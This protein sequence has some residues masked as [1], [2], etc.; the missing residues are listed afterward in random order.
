MKTLSLVFALLAAI[1]LAPLTSYAD[2][3]RG[4]TRPPIR[5]LATT[6]F[7]VSF[8]AYSPKAYIKD[9]RRSGDLVLVDVSFKVTRGYVKNVQIVVD[10]KKVADIP[11]PGNN[12]SGSLTA[13]LSA[14]TM[15]KGTHSVVA[16]A[17]Q[18]RPGHQS[19]IRS[20]K[21]ATFTL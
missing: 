13:K 16:R 3:S 5:R 17:G 2:G 11:I 7:R 4:R 9:I 10:G 19:K 20:S 14:S 6:P 21:P 12:R 15:G 8:A 18:G 1:V